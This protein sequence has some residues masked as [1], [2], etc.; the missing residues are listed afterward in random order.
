MTDYHHGE[1]RFTGYSDDVALV[2]TD[3]GVD[4]FGCYDKPATFDV[5]NKARHGARVILKYAEFNATWSFQVLAYSK[6][7]DEPPFP[8][9]RVSIDRSADVAYSPRLVIDTLGEEVT[10]E[11]ANAQD[12]QA[13]H[14]ER[15][16]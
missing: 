8:E 6:T 7:V 10:I 9:W 3:Q 15:T 11:H 2:E 1:I 4:E 13:A 14:L 16:K 5:L 12:G